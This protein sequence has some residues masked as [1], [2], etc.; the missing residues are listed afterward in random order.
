MP[1]SP[2]AYAVKERITR[3]RESRRQNPVNVYVK[4]TH[5][6]VG[7][8]TQWPISGIIDSGECPPT[9]GVSPSLVQEA[10]IAGGHDA[11]LRR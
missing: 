9:F 5:F 1:I 4:G 10:I 8:G 2:L 7:A 11:M 3:N 6:Y